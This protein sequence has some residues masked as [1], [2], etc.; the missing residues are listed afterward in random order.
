VASF[1]KDGNVWRVQLYVQ[2]RRDSGKFAAEAQATAWTAKRDTELRTG[3]ASGIVKGKTCEDAFRRYEKEVLPTKRGKEW[4]GKRLTAIAD[5]VV[6]GNPV[7]IV[8]RLSKIGQTGNQARATARL[9]PIE[10][11]RQSTHHEIRVA[12]DNDANGVTLDRAYA[13]IANAGHRDPF[14][15][16]R[17]AGRYDLAAMVGCIA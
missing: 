14:D 6:D 3:K 10:R 7:S 17:S 12:F 13:G 1:K 5:M 16:E 8:L 11:H 2:G 9:V 15:D 4:T